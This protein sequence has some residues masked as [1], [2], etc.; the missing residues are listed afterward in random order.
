MRFITG[1]HD[2]ELCFDEVRIR[3]AEAIYGTSGEGEGVHFC[4]SRLYRPLPDVYIEHGNEYDFWNH[5]SD[6]W[7]DKGHALTL[8]P[9][10]I[11]L[12][13]GS[14]YMLRVGYPISLAYPYFDHF[15]PSINILRQIALLCLLD[16]EL[17]IET[18]ERLMGMLS[19]PRTALA[20]LAPGE[21]GVPAR[22]FEHAMLD[23]LAFQQDVEARS[24]EWAGAKSS[25]SK[26]AQENATKEFLTLQHALTLPPAETIAAI[27]TPAVYSMGEDVAN[28]MQQILKSD[29][30]IRYAIAGHTHMW[31]IDSPHDGKQTYLNTGT[32]TKRIALPTPGEM[33]PALVEWLRQPDWKNIPLRDMTQYTFV[34]IATH[35]DG[36]SKVRLCTW[37]G[38]A[39]GSYRVIE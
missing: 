37:E 32:W 36:P 26:E 9:S 15:E 3:I 35:E 11:R 4:T 39:N 6:I 34:M 19:Y 13:F 21:E 29:P 23:F 5:I 12:P 14:Q 16:P 2:I 25:A 1:N 27:C 30:T 20:D 8:S 10:K 17:T 18:A 22:L 28:G 31:R 38:G 33:T 24:P 7:D